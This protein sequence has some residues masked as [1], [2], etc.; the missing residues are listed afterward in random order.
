MCAKSGVKAR[1]AIKLGDNGLLLVRRIEQ[2]PPLLNALVSR[3]LLAVQTV[4]SL[5]SVAGLVI[6]AIHST[7]SVN[8]MNIKK[9]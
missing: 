4:R 9:T 8:Q 3:R 7:L 5:G 2:Q 1:G 6:Q